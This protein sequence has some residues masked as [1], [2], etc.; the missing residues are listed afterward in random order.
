MLVG[1]S[2]WSSQSPP[3]KETEKPQQIS[4]LALIDNLLTA[5]TSLGEKIEKLKFQEFNASDRVELEI[6]ILEQRM[7]TDIT[8][9]AIRLNLF[10]N[11]HFN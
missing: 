2:L 8:I 11:S 4:P 10:A 5:H 6:E 9:T 1:N 7:V 3:P